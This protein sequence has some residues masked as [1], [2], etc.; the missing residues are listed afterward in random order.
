MTYI[1]FSSSMQECVKVL[2]ALTLLFDKVPE[3]DRMKH[4]S[5][6]QG[7]KVL[8]AFMKSGQNL[9]LN[10]TASNRL[11]EWRYQLGVDFN[12][13]AEE[14]LSCSGGGGGSEASNGNG[15]SSSKGGDSEFVEF[16]DRE[17]DDIFPR[18]YDF[19]QWTTKD[20][21]EWLEEVDLGPLK[22]KFRDEDVNGAALPHLTEANIL[23]LAPKIGHQAALRG[24]LSTLVKGKAKAKEVASTGTQKT[25]RFPYFSPFQCPLHLIEP[26]PIDR[27]VLAAVPGA[28]EGGDKS[29]EQAD[30]G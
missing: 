14:V 11:G 1:F 16:V 19:T 3:S 9:L 23:T 30:A 27:Q 22:D 15:S 10:L 29:Q 12:G 5:R 4:D 28:A 20:V 17:E 18:S 2:T 7:V 26:Q 8:G 13:D 6:L 25:V 24:V 21:G